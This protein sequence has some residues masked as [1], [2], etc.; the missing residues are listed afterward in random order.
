[1]TPELR[2]EIR[3]AAIARARQEPPI[4]DEVARQAARILYAASTDRTPELG[5]PDPP[6]PRP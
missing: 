5:V 1:M 4:S 3:Q 6:T 2:E